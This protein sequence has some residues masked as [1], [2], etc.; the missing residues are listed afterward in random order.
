MNRRKGSGINAAAWFAGQSFHGGCHPLPAADA[1][2]PGAIQALGI[3]CKTVPPGEGVARQWAGE[4][5]DG[6]RVI[7]ADKSRSDGPLWFIVLYVAIDLEWRPVFSRDGAS[8][9]EA[10]ERALERFVE[11]L[12]GLRAI[13]VA[14]T[15]CSPPLIKSVAMDAFGLHV[16]VQRSIVDGVPMVDID[17]DDESDEPELRIFVND[18][19]LHE[20]PSIEEVTAERAARGACELCGAEPGE[21]HRRPDCPENEPSPL[22]G[23]P[24]VDPDA[25]IGERDHSETVLLGCTAL[26]VALGQARQR[27][28]RPEL[29]EWAGKIV[30]VHPE[31]YVP[32]DDLVAELAKSGAITR[33]RVGA[34]LAAYLTS[35][36]YPSGTVAKVITV[37]R[38][39]SCGVA[40]DLDGAA[41]EL[42]LPAE[43]LVDAAT[44]RCMTCGHGRQHHGTGCGVA[45]WGDEPCACTEFVGAPPGGCRWC[46]ALA[47]DG[48]DAHRADCPES[49]RQRGA[50]GEGRA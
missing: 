26:A 17:T 32:S 19:V 40:R 34:A 9:E 2:S 23:D 7:V 4:S 28:P 21:G 43:C 16:I 33:E 44:D 12:S 48:D 50:C 6:A 36:G 45:A 13:E 46:G 49:P 8:F 1:P 47:H 24:A 37:N 35:R 27:E 3:E 39:G 41:H 31:R 11:L 18:N 20:H 25:A 14:A 5:G 29:A 38:W 22:D 42:R 30:R 15:E 10:H